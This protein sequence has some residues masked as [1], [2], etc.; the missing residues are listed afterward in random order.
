MYIIILLII[1]QFDLI[2]NIINEH[3]REHVALSGNCVGQDQSQSIP[4]RLRLAINSHNVD[5]L[6]FYD[7][8]IIIGWLYFNNSLICR[9]LLPFF[10]SPNN[11]RNINTGGAVSKNAGTLLHSQLINLHRGHER[12]YNI[13]FLENYP[14]SGQYFR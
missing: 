9:M 5:H 11:L 6:L 7:V 3:V 13:P 10:L 1:I 8:Q 12:V 2:F 4:N 14:F